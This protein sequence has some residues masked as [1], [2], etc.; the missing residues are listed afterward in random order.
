DDLPESF[1]LVANCQVE[2]LKGRQ[3]IYP[4]HQA[5]FRTLCVRFAADDVTQDI[6]EHSGTLLQLSQDALLLWRDKQLLYA[7]QRGSPD[8]TFVLTITKRRGS[9]CVA[10]DGD[11]VL[12]HEEERASPATGG[13]SSPGGGGA[14]RTKLCIG[15]CLS[16]LHLG[17]V[18]IA[19][20]GDES[21]PRE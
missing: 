16:R 4:A 13:R 7:D 20:L 11:V 14:G 8:D 15:G 12:T 3:V 1:Q 17:D 18:S 10:V 5:I 2:F 19:P 9:I 21:A 6:M